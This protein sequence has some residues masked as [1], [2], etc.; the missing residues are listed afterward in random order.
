MSPALIA[1][2][3]LLL[4][5]SVRGTQGDLFKLWGEEFLGDGQRP[6]FGPAALAVGIAA[7]IGYIRPLRGA[8]N[9]LTVLIIFA[10]VAA[11]LRVNNNP[12]AQLSE[13]VVNPSATPAGAGAS[14]RSNVIP[15]R[16]LAPLGSTGG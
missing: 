1:L 6:G 9:G 14:G 2:G 11:N 4:T 3:V 15:L 12:F 16:P 5:S 10:M 7:S 13:F 8:S